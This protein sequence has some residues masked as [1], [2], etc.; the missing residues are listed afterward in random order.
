MR[1]RVPVAGPGPGFR[2]AETE[3]S[4]EVDVRRDDRAIDGLGEAMVD[5]VE[6]WTLRD[7]TRKRLAHC[8]EVNNQHV[9]AASSESGLQ[10]PEVQFDK[11]KASKR[12]HH[13]NQLHRN[14]QVKPCDSINSMVITCD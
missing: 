14:Q 8:L 2:V 9:K 6:C 5:M 13:L 7:R 10:M 11:T 1:R 12:Q 4:V 3:R